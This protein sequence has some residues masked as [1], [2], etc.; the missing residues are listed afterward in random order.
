VA[1]VAPGTGLC[2]KG[3]GYGKNNAWTYLHTAHS[4]VV[5]LFA[6]LE[7]FGCWAGALRPILPCQIP[8]WHTL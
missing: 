6:S 7:Y 2:L 1:W 4:S 5:A 3:K 8:S